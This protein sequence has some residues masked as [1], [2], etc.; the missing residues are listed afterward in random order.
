MQIGISGTEFR[1]P[2]KEGRNFENSLLILYL[3]VHSKA[4]PMYKKLIRQAI[5]A[6]FGIQ[7]K[8]GRGQEFSRD[9]ASIDRT[10]VF[11][12]TSPVVT[13]LLLGDGKDILRVKET[14]RQ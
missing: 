13:R 8:R 9:P 5:S 14:M 7:A 4:I 11:S 1:R 2:C 12:L 3:T 6:S 10:L